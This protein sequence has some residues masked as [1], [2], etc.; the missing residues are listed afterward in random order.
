M[1]TYFGTGSD[2]PPEDSE[3]RAARA[4]RELSDGWVVLHHVSWQSKRNGRQ[5]DGEAD[6]LLLHPSK[7]IIVVEVKG[8][9]IEISN[10]RWWST[11]RY[12]STHQIKNPYEQALA[13][14]YA[15]L[16][17][18]KQHGL[19]E[20]V[21]VGHAVVFPH[22]DE[23]PPLGPVATPA[24]TWTSND[25]AR[26][27]RSVGRTCAHW[28]L[29]SNLSKADM[30]RLI[31]LLAPTVSVRRKLASE[32][33]EADAALLEFTAEQVS[34]FA[35][36]RAARGGLVLGGAGSGKTVLA[37]ARAQQL[38]KDGFR[39]L[40]VCFNELL[41]QFLADRFSDDPLIDACTYH[42]LCFR[43]ARRAG[44]KLP[45][46][47]SSDW[48][49]KEAPEA[50]IEACSANDS[51]YQAIVVDEGQDFAPAW[52]DSLRCL[53]S[54]EADAPFFVFADPRQELWGRDW[55]VG[56]EWQFTYELTQNLR[57]TR[58]IGDKVAAV[59]GG[60]RGRRGV[61]GPL[62]KWRDVHER[63]R[64]ERDV[65]AVVENLIDDGF[66]PAN[67]VVLCS[68]GQ[69]VKRLS[70]FTVGPYSFGTWGGRGIP[71]ET[72]ARF[73]GLDAEAVVLVLDGTETERELMLAYVGMSRAR[74]V[75]VVVGERRLQGPLSWA[76]P[77]ASVTSK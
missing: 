32:S 19:D 9:G 31:Q 49:E 29:S 11:D 57:N 75:L 18:L 35:G 16:T 68:S 56:Q 3:R 54:T 69:L 40:L 72:I 42:S 2:E 51:D 44:L 64:Q 55:S 74:T 20:H 30:A 45:R 23:L 76:Q 26:I 13:S 33:A 7:G 46:E 58:P 62:P 24:I 34:A 50:L 8:G 37:I 60:E 71:V 65:I 1:A 66:G 5:G 4:L 28:E 63:R 59:F 38:A 47:M 15:L 43:E 10:G 21:R 25:L 77:D 48:W 53:I 41:G 27:E 12:G 36:L 67:L 73:K 39:T 70:E 6:F 14:K 17:W 22:L 52:L 61:A